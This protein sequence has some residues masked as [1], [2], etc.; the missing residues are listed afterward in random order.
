MLT[1]LVC[2][3]QK[4]ADSQQARVA[5]GF[6]GE[7]LASQWGSKYA[8][9]VMRGNAYVFPT[10]TAIAMTA[11]GDTLPTLLNP[12][13][14][15]VITVLHKLTIQAAATTTP[16][17]SGFQYGYSNNCGSQVGTASP[18]KTGTPVAAGVN[19]NINSKKQPQTIFFRAV[20]TFTA[21]FSPA[22]LAPVGCN[23][24]A[25]ATT[26][27]W[28]FVDDIDGRICISPGGVFQVG[29]SA[30][31]TDTYNLAYWVYEVPIP[32]TA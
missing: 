14:S 24:G 1:E 15:G 5:S 32:Q 10:T 30:T 20:I 8:Y 2:G 13:G 3:G 7:I 26:Q 27:P 23:L 31:T 6:A 29:C 17:I 18:I 19:L 16:V 4:L 12:L 25:T 28:T 22:L 21:A 11:L 9:Q